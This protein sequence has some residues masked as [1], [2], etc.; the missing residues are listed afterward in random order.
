M[1]ETA[2]QT[3][4]GSGKRQRGG[5]L[6]SGEPAVLLVPWS[7]VNLRRSGINISFHLYNYYCESEPRLPF[8]CQQSPFLQNSNGL[9]RRAARIPEPAADDG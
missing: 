9:T 3:V 4:R 5:A 2:L 8:F 6:S 1:S 7:R